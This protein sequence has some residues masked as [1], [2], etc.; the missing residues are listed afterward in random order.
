MCQYPEEIRSGFCT[1]YNKEIE[2]FINY[3]C[4]ENEQGISRLVKEINRE[5]GICELNYEAEKK[6]IF[7]ECLDNEA[8]DMELLKE[9]GRN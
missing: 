8:G 4:Q 6:I 1:K 3:S 2:A 9:L 5:F 7:Y